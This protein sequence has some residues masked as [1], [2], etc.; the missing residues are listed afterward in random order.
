MNTDAEPDGN[1][2][3]RPLD[4]RGT[5]HSGLDERTRAL[6]CVGAAVALGASAATCQWLVDRA[7]AGGAI[8]EDVIGALVAVAPPVGAARVV[9][10]TPRLAHAIGYDIDTALEV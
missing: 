1:G 4:G 9:A 10:A 2:T 3:T 8:A 5:F 7:L 6:V